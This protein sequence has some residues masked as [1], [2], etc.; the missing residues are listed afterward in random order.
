MRGNLA[1]SK[2]GTLNTPESQKGSLKQ[3]TK[4]TAT[5]TPPLWLGDITLPEKGKQKGVRTP[6]AAAAGLLTTEF[7][8]PHSFKCSVWSW[9][10]K[11]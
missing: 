1:I 7:H 9:L 10:V 8:G 3:T 5:P 2:A 4:K 6:T 11:E